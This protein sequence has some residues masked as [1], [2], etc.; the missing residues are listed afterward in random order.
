MN[1]ACNATLRTHIVTDAVTDAPRTGGTTIQ[2]DADAHCWRV[3]EVHTLA[4]DHHPNGDPSDDPDACHESA[5]GHWYDDTPGATPHVEPVPE[6]VV[7]QMMMN[8]A[9]TAFNNLVKS[10]HSRV[11]EAEMVAIITAALRAQLK[12]NTQ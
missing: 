9:R 2:W 1:T 3:V 6:P 12:G 10:E 8:D 7:T 4:C 5:K 11:S